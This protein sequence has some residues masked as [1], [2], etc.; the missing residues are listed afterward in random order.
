MP[1]RTAKRL[2]D[3]LLNVYRIYRRGGFIARTCLMDMEFEKL[4]GMI[5]EFMINT[6]A[7]RKHVGD[8][9]RYIREIR[10]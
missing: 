9:K 2:K 5:N 6:T 4:V 8:I 3:T 10:E 1:S 7:A